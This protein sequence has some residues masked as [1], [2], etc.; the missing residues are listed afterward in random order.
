MEEAQVLHVTAVNLHAVHEMVH[1]TVA[2]LVAEA[3]VVSEDVAHGLCFEKLNEAKI[4]S[5]NTNFILTPLIHSVMHTA[6]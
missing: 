1:N 2:D 6:A 5:S 4:A 3:E